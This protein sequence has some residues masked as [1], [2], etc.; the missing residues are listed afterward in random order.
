[1][2]KLVAI[3]TL[4]AI[5]FTLTACDLPWFTNTPE[6]PENPENENPETPED[7]EDGG[8]ELPEEPAEPVCDHNYVEIERTEARPLSDGVIISE[9]TLCKEQTTEIHTP[10]TRS[11]KLLAIGN[12]FS[13]DAL[14][15]LWDICHAAG[16]EDLVIGHAYIGGSYIDLHGSYFMYGNPEY[17]YYK[18]EKSAIAE[19]QDKVKIDVPLLDEEWDYIT[20]QNLSEYT[21]ASRFA[22][23][24]YMLGY[25]S[26]KAPDAQI[27]W[28]LTW[29]FSEDCT[30]NG[31]ALH[32]YD[33]M[34]LY[35]AIIGVIDE[36]IAP[37]EEFKGVIPAGTAM[38]NLRTTYI[39][40]NVTRDGYHADLGIGRY[41]IGL[42]WYAIFTG[43][44]LDRVTWVPTNE[45]RTAVLTNLEAIR[46]S[47][48]NALDNPYEITQSKLTE[49]PVAN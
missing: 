46:E 34:K 7:P 40:D 26:A 35:N 47:V 22:M 27:Y 25:I 3:F 30:Y 11:L 2:K 12:S 39:G 36:L 6:V 44:A 45:Y 15:Y 24:D 21:D 33:Q 23:L 37:R 9:C 10:M 18:Y 8:E 41:T 49:S 17:T 4:I 5:V 38:Q 20:L 31:F 19:K 13:N 42:T 29:S 32:D 28:H 14:G 16:I 1:M 48:Q 43:G